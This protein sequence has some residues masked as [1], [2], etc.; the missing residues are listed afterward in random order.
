MGTISPGD[1][2]RSRRL[3]EAITRLIRHEV[4]DLLQSIYATAAILQRRLPADWD[5]ERRIVA[6][7]RARGEACKHLLDAVHDFVCPLTLN[8]ESVNLAEVTAKL[9]AEF[10]SK[11]PQLQLHAEVQASPV[12]QADPKRIAQLGNLLL[13]NACEAAQRHVRFRTLAGPDAGEVEW[14]V[15]DDG[16][17]V[18]ADQLEH[19]FS[20]LATTRHGHLGV[21][22]AMARKLVL[23]HG[24]RI[25]AE[26]LPGGGFCV[27]VVLPSVPPPESRQW[28]TAANFFAGET[29]EGSGTVERPA[30]ETQ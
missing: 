10:T 2:R 23:L 8:L 1:S 3:P 25:S 12:I 13:T 20:P 15:T 21:G 14:T 11:H 28:E 9:M 30:K 22:L 18:P 19:L 26:N 7:L 6:D 4:G 5:L 29:D 17:G 16:T 24:G 27:R